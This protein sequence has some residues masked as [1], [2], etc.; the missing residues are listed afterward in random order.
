MST[1]KGW[2][3]SSYSGG[4]NSTCVTVNLYLEEGIVGLRDSKEDGNPTR[5][6]LAVRR[7]AFANFLVDC[8]TGR[9]LA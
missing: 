7:A 9:F 1:R 3:K 6:V 2:R 4:A 8:K 5:T